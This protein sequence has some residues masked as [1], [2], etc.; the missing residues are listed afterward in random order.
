MDAYNEKCL[1]A[2]NTCSRSHS[3]GDCFNAYN[4]CFFDVEIATGNASPI[5]F[6]PYDI[7][8][9]YP[10]SFPSQ[11]YLTYLQS[12]KVM[13]AI[14]ARVPFQDCSDTVTQKFNKTG[15]SMPTP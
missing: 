3:D 9:S 12:K 10:D 14:G 15:D 11:E 6:D 1:P 2:L 8:H 7:R 5:P 13:D 4:T